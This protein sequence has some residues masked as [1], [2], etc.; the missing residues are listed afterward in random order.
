MTSTP[1]KRPQHA[2]YEGNE[3]GLLCFNPMLPFL[4]R[5]LAY[6]AF[7]DYKT[8]ED[9][10]TI[11][12]PEDEMLVLQWKDDLLETPFFKSQSTDNIETAAAFSHRQRLLGLRAGYATPPRHH[13]IRAE[14]LHLM[15]LFESEATR[16]VYAGHT[17]PNTLPK[18]YLPRNSADGQAAY[19]GQ[20]RRGICLP[21]K[22]QFEFE[23]SPEFIRINKEL[24]KR[25]GTSDSKSSQERIKLY[26]EKRK[27]LAKEL[28]DWQKRQP[29]KH[30]DAP[31]YHR[32]IFDRVRFMMPERDRLAQNLFEID[33]LRSPIGLSVLRDML[34][35]YQ[36]SSNVE[37]RPG[38]EPDKCPCGKGNDS[39]YDWRHVYAY[40]KAAMAKAYGFAELCFLCNEWFH[41]TE[42]WGAHC[43]HHLDHPDSLPVWCDPLTYGGVLARAGY[44]PFCLGDRNLPASVRMHQFKIRWTW[45]DHIQTHIRTLEG[46]DMPVHCPIL[47]PTCPGVFKSVQELQFHLQDAF[48]VE[49]NRDS[50]KIKRPRYEKREAAASGVP[51]PF[52]EFHSF[53]G[54]TYYS[55]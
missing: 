22:K 26:A 30:D 37:Y 50:T 17:D 46:G 15:N 12:P 32:A 19:H 34:A 35:L 42:A 9:L 33:T 29:V 1:D 45:L 18:H 14:G 49:R 8:I 38:L 24:V 47:H 2:L 54:L 39:S 48:G 52:S 16:M 21:A 41:C 31:G 44:C 6:E 4:A 27:M 5:L 10:L 43:Q 36:K 20:K 11:V 23:N 7:R 28:R 13:D 25:R 53:L 3:P 40:F 51:R 55:C